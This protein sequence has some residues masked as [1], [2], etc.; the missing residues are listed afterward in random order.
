[1][2]TPTTRTRREAA[3]F[4]P[5]TVAAT[6]S[7]TPRL[8]RLTLRG[9]ALAGFERPEPAA[10]IRLLIPERPGAA[11]VLPEWAGNEWLLPDGR[12]AKEWIRTFTPGD[13][14]GGDD[15]PGAPELD[16]DVVLHGGGIVSD[17]AASAEPG[18]A[19]AVSGPQRGYVPDPAAPRFLVAGD[20]SALPAIG[21]VLAAIPAGTPVDVHVEVAAPEGRLE[22]PH[23]DAVHVTWHDAD[24]TAPPG[25]ALVAAV[26]A[27]DIPPGTRVWVAGEAASVQR[28]RKHL[29]DE[30]GLRR[31]DAHVRGYWKHGR[32]GA[33]VG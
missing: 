3:P 18:A 28:V 32:A 8:L 26:A 33:D 5:V 7:L 6:R 1:V 25:D 15:A 14:R 20:E 17:W 21:Q 23:R 22:L 16:V 4:R 12:R 24:P 27:A 31:A 13:L 29:F 19:A 11:L 10:S 2:T 30:R 9:P